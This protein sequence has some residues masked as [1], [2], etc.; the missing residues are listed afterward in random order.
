M[1]SRETV[2]KKP[3]DTKGTLLRLLRYV[4]AYKWLLAFIIALCFVSNFLALLGP[5]MAGSAINAASAGAG[6][7]DFDQ[8]YYYAKRM[9]FC[10]LLR[11]HN[12]HQHDDDVHLEVDCQEDAGGRVP[13]AHAAAGGI[14]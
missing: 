10:V 6:K 13:Q 12:L 4:G 9:L 8:V 1:A 7:V 11:G 3:K 2:R 5:S 14:F